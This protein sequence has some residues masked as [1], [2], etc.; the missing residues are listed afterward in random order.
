MCRCN[1]FVELITAISWSTAISDAL[2]MLLLCSHTRLDPSI[3]YDITV[4]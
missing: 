4:I 2:L 3:S 1:D